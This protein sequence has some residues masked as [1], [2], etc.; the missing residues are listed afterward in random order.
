[1]FDAED[2]PAPDQLHRALDV[3]LADETIACVQARLTIDN[4][5]DGWLARGIMA[6]TPPKF[7][8]A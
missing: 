3:F 2:R 4:T 8:C 7:H 5:A 1:V 6:Q